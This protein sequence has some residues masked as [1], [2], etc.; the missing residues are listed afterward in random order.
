MLKIAG[1]SLSVLL[2]SLLIKEK[3]RTFAVIL[4]IT[5]GVL[6]FSVFISELS[7]VVERVRSLTEKSEISTSYIALMVKALG[8]TILTQF[9]SD[10]CRDNG[11]NALASITETV[12]KI[13]VVAMLFP[14]FETIIEIVGGLVK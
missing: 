1:I 14:L 3:N 5:G 11:E 7:E 2:C 8:I 9:V 13:A 4:S 12:A 6:L 10:I